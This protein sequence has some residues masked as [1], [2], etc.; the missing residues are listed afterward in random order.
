LEQLE[1][2]P[3]RKED[4]KQLGELLDRILE[5]LEQLGEPPKTCAKDLEQLGEPPD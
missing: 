1:E 5:D 2:P 3:G 4:L